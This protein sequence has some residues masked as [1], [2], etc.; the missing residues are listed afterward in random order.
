[1]LPIVILPNYIWDNTKKTDIVIIELIQESISIGRMELAVIW[2]LCVY[3]I[4][5]SYSI[6]KYRIGHGVPTTRFK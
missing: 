5:Q 4:F 3:I 2:N 6:I 1:M